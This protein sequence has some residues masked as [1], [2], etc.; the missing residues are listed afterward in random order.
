MLNLCVSSIVQYTICTLLYPFDASLAQARQR[1]YRFNGGPYTWP[2]ILAGLEKVAGSK[3]QITY[4]PV[5]K[6]AEREKL[7]KE[8]GD[9]DLELEASH[10]LVQGGEGTL[11]PLPHDNDRFPE[12]KLISLEE[13]LKGALKLMAEHGFM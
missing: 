3:Y 2:Q 7:A 6:A 11:L 12:I 10:Q 5:K 8:T 13:S 4:L 9:V 1:T